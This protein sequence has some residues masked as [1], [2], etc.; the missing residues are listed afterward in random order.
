M[1]KAFHTLLAVVFA[2]LL[3]LCAAQS[4]TQTPAADAS[5]HVFQFN[6][7]YDG[8]TEIKRDGIV[9]SAAETEEALPNRGF[10][11]SRGLLC[12]WD[13]TPESAV[14]WDAN[15]S[16]DEWSKAVDLHIYWDDK[17]GAG[18]NCVSYGANQRINIYSYGDA[19]D[20]YCATTSVV[21]NAGVIQSSTLW[22]NRLADNASC[23]QTFTLRQ[24][25]MSGGIGNALG[26]AYHTQNVDSVMNAWLT[27]R[28]RTPYPRPA[29]FAAVDGFY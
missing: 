8:T 24:N 6:Q 11:F 5:R 9:L 26:M 7:K 12:L 21:Q 22:M 25:I 1:R 3:G 2:A 20:G 10:K 17:N 14:S 4:A 27:F 23:R 29:D 13:Y 18:D 15:R 19:A 28:L 16:G